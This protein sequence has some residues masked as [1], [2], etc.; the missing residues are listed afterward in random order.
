MSFLKPLED[1]LEGP[2]QVKNR[3]LCQGRRFLVG[4]RGFFGDVGKHVFL[5]ACFLSQSPSSVFELLIF[6]QLPDELP[7]RVIFFTVLFWRL[8]TAR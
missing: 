2:N 6:N 7:P 4:G 1:A 5:F 8:L 3:N